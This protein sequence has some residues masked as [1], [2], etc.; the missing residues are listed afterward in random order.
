ML[1][2]A[3]L[4]RAALVLG[5]V[6]VPSVALLLGAVSAPLVA[7]VLVVA[8]LLREVWALLVVST[9]EMVSTPSAGASGCL[10]LL[11]IFCHAGHDLTS[12]LAALLVINIQA[13]PCA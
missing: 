9:C 13:A 10:F 4:F 5:V 6:L 7:S 3:S 2:V 1:G 8:L 11:L 12:F